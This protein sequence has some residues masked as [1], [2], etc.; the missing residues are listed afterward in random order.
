MS[1]L[2][3]PPDRGAPP[4]PPDITPDTAASIPKLSLQNPDI[5]GLTPE[6]AKN[7]RLLEGV[8][9]KYIVPTDVPKLTHIPE[10]SA[11]EFPESQYGTGYISNDE[12][13]AVKIIDFVKLVKR[14]RPTSIEGLAESLISELINYHAISELCP[15]YFCKLIGYNYDSNTHILTIVMENCGKDLFEMYSEPMKRP[16]SDVV[17]NHIG[18]LLNILN[19]LHENNFVHFDLKLENI[20]IDRNGTLKLIDAGTLIDTTESNFPEVLVRGTNIYMAP[21]LKTVLRNKGPRKIANNEL[22]MATDI[23][24]FGILLIIMIFPPNLGVKKVYNESGENVFNLWI[25]I[26]S[27]EQII[28]NIKREFG[29]YF[30]DKI[31]FNHFFGVDPRQRLTIQELKSMFEEKME[32]EQII[33]TSPTGQIKRGADEPNVFMPRKKRA[34]AVVKPNASAIISR[35]DASANLVVKNQYNLSFVFWLFNYFYF[36]LFIISS[37][38]FLVLSTNIPHS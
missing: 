29:N 32:T 11:N 24:S 4:K 34:K 9:T 13:Y 8:I 5:M 19:C 31:E 37:F 36:W 27:R 10:P 38:L 14:T 16:R 25:R 22:L 20:V 12:K 3:K 18:Q 23:Y 28:E 6:Q 15:D 33:S 30:G 7:I 35:K 26:Y 17:R 2:P 21:E 1:E